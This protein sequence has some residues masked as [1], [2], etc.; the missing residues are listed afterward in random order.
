MSL[1]RVRQIKDSRPLPSKSKNWPY[2]KK[3]Q[4]YLWHHSRSDVTSSLNYYM[5]HGISGCFQYCITHTKLGLPPIIEDLVLKNN[6]IVLPWQIFCRNLGSA[7]HCSCCCHGLRS[8]RHCLLQ[9]ECLILLFS[10][11]THLHFLMFKNDGGNSQTNKS[12]PFNIAKGIRNPGID[13]FNFI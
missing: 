9:H 12:E 2:P 3:I 13:Y 4:Q 10:L 11:M 8:P 5:F 7:N 6:P 1:F